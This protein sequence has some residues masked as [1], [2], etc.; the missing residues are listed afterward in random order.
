MKTD[1]EIKTMTREEWHTLGVELFGSDYEKWL[2]VCPSCGNIASIGDYRKYK[3]KGAT[4]DS[5]TF[6]CIGRYMDGKVADM[7]S[8]ERP[9]NYSSGG[10]FCINTLRII[11]DG[12]NVPCFEFAT[13][14][15]K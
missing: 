9:C 12:K 15:G 3:D 4:P 7:C 10:L 6:N 1:R 14:E 5:A 11:V 8:G 2:F 13:V